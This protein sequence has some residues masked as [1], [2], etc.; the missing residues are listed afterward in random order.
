LGT[1]P[2]GYAAYYMTYFP[3]EGMA[4]HNNYIDIIAQTGIVGSIFFLWFLFAH[5]RGSRQIRRMLQGRGD[6][7]ESLAVA[8]LAGSVGCIVAMALGDWMF[9]FAY[10]QG[11]IGFDSALF[12]WFFMGSIWAL[13]YSLNL[14]TSTSNGLVRQGATT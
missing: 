8:A 12:N 4:T 11:I 5:V 9:P 6:F 14:E 2:A 13:R 1:G 10:T 3:M 7:A